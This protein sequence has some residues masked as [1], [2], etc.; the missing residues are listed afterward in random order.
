MKIKLFS[1]NSVLKI[2]DKVG[3]GKYVAF[4]SKEGKSFRGR[5]FSRLL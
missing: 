1:K 2:D 5:T 4:E 3:V